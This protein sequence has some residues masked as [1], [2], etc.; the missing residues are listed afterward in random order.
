MIG[1]FCYFANM[2]LKKVNKY[3]D[4]GIEKILADKNLSA[5]FGTYYFQLT[6]D[7]ICVGCSGK[8]RQK[9]NDLMNTNQ[10][11]LK[12]MSEQ[13][14][15][16]E[17]GKLIDRSMASK[18]LSGQYTASNM[19]DE[20]ALQLL[21]SH[22]G[23]IKFFKSFPKNWEELAGK[24]KFP[25]APKPKAPAAAASSEIQEAEG[26]TED[27]APADTNEASH[28]DIVEINKPSVDH[29]AKEV[30]SMLE[31]LHDTEMIERWTA[32][33]ADLPKKRK[34]VLKAIKKRL[35]Q[36]SQ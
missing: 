2:S 11:K 18:G 17:P 19:T 28:T 31:N 12:A 25:T 36:L 1:F 3:R 21:K 27:N 33:E 20:I 16:M 32:G 15:I 26:S 23:Y 29:N 9:F 22:K 34:T 5:E 4:I 10:Q 14:F 7:K 30:I 6:G 13:K 35:R 8:M 24:A